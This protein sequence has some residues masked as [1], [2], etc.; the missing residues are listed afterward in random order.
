MEGGHQPDRNARRGKRRRGNAGL[1][2]DRQPHEA[3]IDGDDGRYG[4]RRR[5]PADT[6]ASGRILRPAVSGGNDAEAGGKPG[7]DE[8]PHDMSLLR[9]IIRRMGLN[10]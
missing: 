3:A 5:C 10:A 4:K 7:N 6:P 9:S 2:G 8:G 1:K